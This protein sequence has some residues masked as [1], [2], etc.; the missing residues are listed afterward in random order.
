MKITSRDVAKLDRGA[1]LTDRRVLIESCIG[2][3]YRD[4]DEMIDCAQQV[5]VIYR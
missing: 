4:H 2:K 1:E 3:L 5:H